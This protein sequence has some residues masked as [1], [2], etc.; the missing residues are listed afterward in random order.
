MEP[1]AP[2]VV[3]L[4]TALE[5]FLPVTTLLAVSLTGVLLWLVM[6]IVNERRS[7]RISLGTGGVES[8]ERASRAH[9]N[10]VETAPVALILCALAEA[11][12]APGWLL[13]PTALAFLIGRVLHA[14]AFLGAAMDFR[15]RMWGMVITIL[16]LGGLAVTA[17]GSL[18][19]PGA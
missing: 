8:L 11:Q 12:G 18:W 15:G 7:N 16:T 14:L 2:D 10:L 4:E 17:L 3:E 6:R 13:A 1:V 5:L 19:P 9:G